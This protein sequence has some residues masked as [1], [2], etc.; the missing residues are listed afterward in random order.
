LLR[1]A[2]LD[3]IGLPPTL[4]ETEAFLADQDPA[5]FERAIDRLLASPGYGERWGRHWLDLVRYAD[6][7]GMDDNLAYSDAW[8]YRDYVIAAFNADRRFDRFLKEQLAGDLLAEAEPEGRDELIVA[9]GF[10][11]I[12]PKMLAEDDPVKQ[13]M[14]IV[15]EQLDTTSRVFMALT[16]GCARCHDHKFDPLEQSDYYALAG[17]FKSTQTMIS[18]RVDSKWN[19]TAL[20]SIQAALR[21]DDL[22]Q[23]IDRH[24]NLLVNG[25]PDRMPAGAREAHTELLTAAKREYAAIPKAMA[26]VEGIPGDL[27]VFLRGNHLTR[28]PVVARR[29]P[30]ILTDRDAPAL[31]PKHSGRL[32][33]ARW[34][35]AASHPL[36]A[37]VIVNRVW[38]WHFGRGLV[39]SVDN[40][41]KLGSRPTHPELLDWLANR[42]V[43]HEWS[44]KRLHKEIML[45]QTYQMSS[46]WDARASAIDP[47]NSLLWRMPRRRLEAEELRDSILAAAGLLET[48]MRGTLLASSPFQDLSAEG[49]SRSRSLYE[50]SR[51]SVYLP[52][53]RGALHEMYR[54][55]DFPDP[56][57]SSGDRAVTTVATQALFMMNSAL[58]ASACSKL[59]AGL[60]ADDFITE[61][62]RLARACQS[63]LG[64]PA[65]PEEL[66]EWSA[67]LERYQKIAISSGQGPGARR[68]MAWE[69]LC[70]ALLSSNEFVYVE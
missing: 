13:Q 31:D 51:R 47:E 20:G 55:F 69:G 43:S 17:I 38:R 5:A 6:S 68:R 24:D 14:D 66:A 25:N 61:K 19:T 26:V 53:L 63:I 34:L 29:F 57:S 28:G 23:I 27:E 12:G 41:G 3:L 64:R 59:A 50:S 7:N 70:R 65:L 58:V 32:E 42:L 33:L 9:T 36:T 62:D 49:V 30:A 48:R 8:R 21:L 60:L 35:S 37:R 52:V 15:D 44:L 18:H 39:S 2:T 40:F 56:A 10:L 22:E 11:A 54:T 67:F 1:R 4:L 16:M 46:R 45:S